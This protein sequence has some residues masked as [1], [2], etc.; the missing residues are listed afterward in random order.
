MDGFPKTVVAAMDMLRPFEKP[1]TVV[2][3]TPDQ[4]V[5]VYFKRKR[6]LKDGHIG[7]RRIK[8]MNMIIMIMFVKKL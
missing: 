8:Q 3:I 6:Y 5:Y 1:V 4:R 2:L 7:A